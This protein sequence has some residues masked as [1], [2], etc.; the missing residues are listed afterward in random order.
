M[1]NSVYNK[2]KADMISSKR[3][4][5]GIFNSIEKARANTMVDSYSLAEAKEELPSYVYKEFAAKKQNIDYLVNCD[6]D[7]EKTFLEIK[8]LDFEKV[9]KN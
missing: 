2:I 5:T 4:H 6:K 9:L 8:P 3:V 7:L 1:D